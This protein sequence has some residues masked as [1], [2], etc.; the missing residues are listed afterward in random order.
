LH[1]IHEMLEPGSLDHLAYS[2][3]PGFNHE[4]RNPHL[5]G[6]GNIA[7]GIAG[8]NGSAIMS[9][10]LAMVEIL[11]LAP[12]PNMLYMDDVCSG[13]MTPRCPAGNFASLCLLHMNLLNAS[14]TII[15]IHPYG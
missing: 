9:V 15:I 6:L 4:G 7:F 8:L 11:G 10:L 5:L 12:T 13:T 3:P 2:M 14:L 1:D